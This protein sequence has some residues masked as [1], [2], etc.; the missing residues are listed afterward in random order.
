[1]LYRIIHV[2]IFILTC[3]ASFAQEE[4]PKY[5][6]QK[7]TVIGLNLTQNSFDNWAQGGENSF[8]W[9]GNF[10][11]KFENVQQKLNWL[12]AGRFNYGM[13]KAG[14]DEMKKSIDELKLETVLSYKAGIHVDPYISITA[15]SQVGPGY[16]YDSE[17]KTKISRFMDPG[18]VRES[19]G[20]GYKPNKTI[21]TR[22]GIAVKHTLVQDTKIV[23]A[24]N[25]LGA[26][27]VTDISW[28]FTETSKIDSKLELFSNLE[29]ADQVD[30]NWDTIL[31]TKITKY[32][33]M[34]FNV[35]LVYDKDIST[36]RQLKQVL[37]I[38]FSYSFF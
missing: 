29:A 11:Y 4:A 6:W 8:S 9:Q 34:N 13:I 2:Y 5:G 18:Y 14:D 33:N 15:E 22:V 32:L 24:Q 1:M 23:V 19:I 12:N 27:S 7:E 30:V 17:L 35:K 28:K 3:V 21:T 10:N 38:G 16:N 37:G 25:E 36:K 31:T 20:L 26:E